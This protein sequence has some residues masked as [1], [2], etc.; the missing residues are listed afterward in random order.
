MVLYLYHS[1]SNHTVVLKNYSRMYRYRY[2]II[3]CALSLDYL[4]RMCHLD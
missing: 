4:L 2:G 1:L 3:Q